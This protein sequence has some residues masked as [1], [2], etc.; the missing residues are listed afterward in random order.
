MK[1]NKILSLILVLMMVFSLLAGISSRVE[2]T[3]GYP[4]LENVKIDK[5][6]TVTWDAYPG[7]FT[8]QVYP[9]G[10]AGGPEPDREFSFKEFLA[11]MKAPSGTYSIVIDAMD[12]DYKTIAQYELSWYYKEA[13]RSPMNVY[14]DNWQM[15]WW[16][17]DEGVV[18]YGSLYRDGE[19]LFDF[20]TPEM[21]PMDVSDYVVGADHEY[22]F[23]IRATKDGYEPSITVTSATIKGRMIDR[24]YGSDR[25]GTTTAVASRLRE[26][27]DPYKPYKCMVLVSGKNFPDALSGSFFASVHNAPLLLVSEGSRDRI[28]DYI[29]NN[30]E[31]G[32]T[33]YVLGGTGAVPDSCLEGLEPRYTVKRLYGKNRYDTNIAILKDLGIGSGRILVCTGENFADSLSASAV[34][35]PMLLVK[36]KLNNDQKEFLK[37]L[38][39]PQFFIIGG[40]GAVS[41]TIAEELREYGTVETRIYGKN[42][43]ETS[44]KIAQIFFLKPKYAVLATGKN[45]PDGLSGGP[46]AYHL[47]APL[48]LVD[49]K[50][51]PDVAAY[52]E[53]IKVMEGY[54]LGG[55]GV[56]SQEVLEEAFRITATE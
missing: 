50:G 45:F 10:Y 4:D 32:S 53:D 8:Y 23:S 29:V 55:T 2:A 22:Y 27:I 3:G 12:E 28:Y 15:L 35:Y 1:H 17:P 25:Y 54:V 31:D 41:E 9:V 39:N 19:V 47:H 20:G 48:I 51:N 43:Y 46:L 33:I 21:G 37:N 36:D 6:G 49:P 38:N 30:L 44:L 34:P 11:E 52:L 5:D 40:T 18:F 7:A 42:R 56:V 26:T 13:V 16:H 24:L 14:W